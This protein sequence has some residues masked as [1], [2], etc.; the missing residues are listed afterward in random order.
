MS[1]M[2]ELWESV[3]PVHALV[4]GCGGHHRAV[5]SH[6]P[7]KRIMIFKELANRSH[8][9]DVAVRRVIHS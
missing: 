6:P 1:V 8:K 2:Y 5:M 7:T 4:I 3:S 9:L